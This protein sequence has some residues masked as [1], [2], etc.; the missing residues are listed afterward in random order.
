M[1][2]YELQPVDTLFFRDARPMQSNAGS[3]G[4]GAHWPMPPVVQEALRAAL[5]RAESIPLQ[6]GQPRGHLRNGRRPFIVTEAFRSLHIHGPFPLKTEAGGQRFYL[7]WPKDV[8]MQAK[9][10]S[11]VLKRLSPV[12]QPTGRSDLPPWLHPLVSEERAGKEVVPDWMPLDSFIKTLGAV[13]PGAWQ[14][15]AALFDVEHRI[16]IGIDPESRSTR[17]GQFYSAEHLRLRDHVSLWFSARLEGNRAENLGKSDLVHLVG[18]TLTVGG[19]SRQCR[20]AA[21]KPMPEIPRPRGRLIKWVLA[22][23]AVFNGGW[24]PNWIRAEDGHVLLRSGEVE[25]RAAEDRRSWR[26]RVQQLPEIKARLVAACVSKPVPFSG[27]DLSLPAGSG[28]QAA[29]GGP[30][31]TLLAVPA[32]TVYFFEAETE[33]DGA[34]LVRALHGRTYSDFLGEKGLGLGFCG[35]WNYVDVGGRPLHGKSN[36]QPV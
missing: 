19:E 27:W 32:G 21:G 2:A 14:A 36:N 17:E 25:R 11:A 13:E 12:A 24:R 10:D 20:L 6:P 23:H 26:A 30:K 22:T 3:G 28:D 16:G 31:P 34:A 5:L 33:A 29:S 4:H 18:Q 9:G 8:V 15:E 35:T 1:K 7:P